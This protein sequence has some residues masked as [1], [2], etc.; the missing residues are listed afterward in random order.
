MNKREDIYKITSVVLMLDQ[1]IKIIIMKNMELNT[2]ITLIPNFF[3]LFY[4]KN[5]GAAFS[6]FKN[7]T[8]FLIILSVIIVVILD[9]YIK[10]EKEFTKLSTFSLGIIMGGI[11]G[12]LLDRIIHHSVIDYLSFNI[13]NYSFPIFNL[14]DIGITVGVV[15]L[16]IESIR[17]DKKI[18]KK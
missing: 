2:K 1:F 3:S 6:I 10:K 13:I 5:T 17:K 9:R 15:L 14:A 7:N 18:K 4:V 12:N 16:L 11:F 8:L